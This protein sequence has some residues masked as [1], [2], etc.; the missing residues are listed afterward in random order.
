MSA[1]SLE[2]TPF[3]VGSWTADPRANELLREGETVRVEPKVMAL[4]V[5][6]AEQ[7]RMP[8]SREDLLARVWPDV[9]VTEDALSRAVSK[10][11][12][13]LGEE[14][15][16][17]ET[18]PTVGYRLRVLVSLTQAS[19][20]DP[21]Q[22]VT[23]WWLMAGGVVLVVSVWAWWMAAQG[24]RYTPPT[25]RIV[26]HL[27]GVE[28]HPA[29]SPDGRR[30]AFAAQGRDE[31]SGDLWVMDLGDETP[32][33][34]TETPEQE[35]YPTWSPDGT[36]LAFLRCEGAVCGLYTMP[37]LGGGARRV[38]DASFGAWGLAWFPDGEA[39]AAIARTTPEM[40]YRIMRVEVA[41]G[42]VESLTAPS[43]A[44][45]MIGDLFPALHPE[46]EAVAF[47]RHGASGEEDVWIQPLD[48]GDARQLT[49]D[50]VP[51]DGVAW[52]PDGQAVVMASRRTGTDALWRV[53]LDGTALEALPLAVGVARL[54]TL[55]AGRL[56]VEVRTH[57]VNLYVGEA[58][59]EG[60]EPAIVSTSRD[61]QPSIAPE[62]ERLAFVSDRSGSPE[63]WTAQIDGSALVRLTGFGGARL[64]AP[65][66]SPDGRWIVFE[67]QEEGVAVIYRIGAEGGPV[68]RLTEGEGYAL[69]PRVSRESQF[70]YFGSN[71][72]ETWRLWR[73]PMD[74]GTPDT[75]APPGHYVGEDAVEEGALLTAHY[76]EPGLWRRRPGEAAPER[77]DS[78]LAY[79]DWGS[80]R[81]TTQGILLLERTEGEARLVRFDSETGTRT[82]L[83]DGLVGIPT[84]EPA[85]DATPDG[86]RYVLA[87]ED[88]VESHL[89]LI[90][91]ID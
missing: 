52:T 30:L 49:T 58:G 70:V 84:R 76:R 55:A 74:G 78:L 91:P 7:A 28:T 43:T 21:A 48:G 54:P 60:L 3:Q 46:G 19:S 17:V 5:V 8:V 2:N 87:R 44:C 32:A 64:G 38:S 24:S 16:A 61:A 73:V 39:F 81:P 20:A 89:V 69:A 26:T 9:V 13:A 57:E 11:R 40:P 31:A 18:I 4:L 80:W 85:F 12:R 33:R 79:T 27:P 34:L 45:G 10:L 1:S 63:L 15:E 23:R 65:R 75:V 83:R 68:T 22:Q 41:T 62:G 47:I 71:R 37:A 35:R 29:L 50:G 88:R 56:A 90:T 72:D 36:R 25:A 86:R 67:V 51:I 59:R 14:A 53:P 66:W 42:Q 6:L 77:I 82:V